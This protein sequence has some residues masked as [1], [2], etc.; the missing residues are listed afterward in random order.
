M[1][2][3]ILEELEWELAWELP[4]APMLSLQLLFSPFPFSISSQVLFYLVILFLYIF[5]KR[6]SRHPTLPAS[7]FYSSLLLQGL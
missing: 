6:L 1:K 3:F 7:T 5:H 2:L 4:P